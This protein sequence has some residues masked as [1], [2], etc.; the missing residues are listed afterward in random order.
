MLIEFA[1]VTSISERFFLA[2]NCSLFIN[3]RDKNQFAALT[4]WLIV[5]SFALT[6]KCSSRYVKF[7][8]F[9][10][11]VEKGLP[12]TRVINRVALQVV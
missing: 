6:S 12:V 11:A 1:K 2:A 10:P 8:T 7:D 9:H 4:L 3:L 5:N